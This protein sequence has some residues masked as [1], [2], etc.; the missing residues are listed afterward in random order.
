MPPFFG[1]SY[2][3][4]YMVQ[5]IQDSIRQTVQLYLAEYDSSYDLTVVLV[6]QLTKQETTQNVTG[7][8]NDRRVL[9]DL[10]LTNHETGMYIMEVS[11][12]QKNLGRFLVYLSAA[13]NKPLPTKPYRT[14]S[15]VPEPDVVYNG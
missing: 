8:K 2:I 12:P 7:F 11:Q 6:N 15:T 4:R 9:F 14:Y 1:L 13:A 5:L 10:D 3:V